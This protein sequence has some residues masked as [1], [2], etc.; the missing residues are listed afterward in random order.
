M[1]L[2]KLAKKS[3]ILLGVMVPCVVAW[4]AWSIWTFPCGDRTPSDAAI[5]LGAAAHNGEPSP[6][7]IERI[8]HGLKLHKE[9]VVG[10]LILTGGAMDD[11][12]VTL[13]EVA[14][15]Y[16]LNRGVP[17]EDMILEPYSRIT[18][19]NLD[20]AGKI[21]EGKGL[22]TFLI[23]SDPLHMRRAMRIATDLHMNAKASATPTTRYTDLKGRLLF[24][25]RETRLYLQY[26]LANRFI[27]RRSLEEAEKER[28]SSATPP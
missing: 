11:E 19:E 26:V 13:A 16:A 23:V 12:S 17:A 15:R 24:L 20:Y 27:H 8:N 3:A 4:T 7:F 25:G 21:A 22:R 28:P 6:V 9:G 2:K 1:N 14:F 10:K 5:V 18:Y